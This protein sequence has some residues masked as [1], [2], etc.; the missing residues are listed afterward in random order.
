[1]ATYRYPPA[2]VEELASHGLAPKSDTPPERLRDQVR[3]LYRF[4]IRRLRDR[5]RSGE[6]PTRELSAHVIELRKRYTLLSIP[7]D[8]WGG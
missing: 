4:E 7:I 1:M 5:C 3:D 8:R 6:I 2:I